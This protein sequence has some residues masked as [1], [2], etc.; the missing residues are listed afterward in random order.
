MAAVGLPKIQSK[1]VFQPEGGQNTSFSHDPQKGKFAP[2]K[3]ASLSKISS[4]PFIE[5]FF[6][7][8]MGSPYQ[9]KE[10]PRRPSTS[11]ARRP[12]V[13]QKLSP[14][15]R[16]I[17]P[18]TFQEQLSFVQCL[19]TSS[20]NR[21]KFQY[22]SSLDL[23][24]PTGVNL[25]NAT[26]DKIL[27]ECDTIVSKIWKFLSP[28][29]KNPFFLCNHNQFSSSIDEFVAYLDLGLKY[30]TH[31]IQ[32]VLSSQEGRNLFY[33]YSFIELP[34]KPEEVSLIFHKKFFETCEAI[35]ATIHEALTVTQASAA[36]VDSGD[37]SI[38]RNP[39]AFI[40]LLHRH[41]DMNFIIRG[42]LF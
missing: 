35:M 32:T 36:A 27:N 19:L 15:I 11:T 8:E 31:F 29:D 22:F 25:T 5:N 39:D 42:Y 30:Q 34:R 16:P 7:K 21:V 33:Q 37:P 28:Q 14:L 23:P 40:A 1:Y 38:M 6:K 18:T 26:L 12:L 20:E 24:D 4:A 3:A 17:R 13:S 10:P 41:R 9:T 2:Q